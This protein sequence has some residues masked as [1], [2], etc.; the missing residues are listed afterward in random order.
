VRGRILAVV[1]EMTASLGFAP[2]LR[3]SGPI[4]TLVPDHIADQMLVAL[5]EALANVAKHAQA[6]RADVTVE[7]GPDLVLTV[8]DN[9]IGLTKTTRRSGLANLADRAAELGGSLRTTA[10]EGGGTELE[11]RVPLRTQ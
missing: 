10:A 1:D 11:W 6:S 8:R 4:D 5:R 2:A 9:G 3:M 7:V